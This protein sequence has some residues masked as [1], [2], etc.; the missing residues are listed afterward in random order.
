MVKNLPVVQETWVQAL[1][2]EDPLEKGM[3][4]PLQYSCQES[5]R[6]RGAWGAAAHGVAKHRMQLND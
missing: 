4:D 1:G 2:W 6:D 3:V 5:L